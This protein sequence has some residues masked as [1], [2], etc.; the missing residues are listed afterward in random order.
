MVLKGLALLP[1]QVTKTEALKIFELLSVVN[2]KIGKIDSDIKNSVV[3]K[4]LI[5]SLSLKESVQSTRIEGTQVTF[6]EMVEEMNDK[7]PRW[8]IIEV[9]NYEQAL[10]EGVE[11]IRHGY[12]IST[13]LL[14]EL[15]S[16]LMH[17]ARGSRQS[18]GE[19]RK[20]Q[21]FI[22]PSTKIE[23]A[24][25]L[26]IGANEIGEYMSNLEHF[27]NGEHHFSYDKRV[28][29]DMY[30]FDETAPP[31]V[32]T[33]IIHAQFESI[34]PFLDGNGRLGR[35]LIVLSM[36]NENLTTEPI[37]LVSEELE[38]EKAR[39]YDML[40]EVRGDSPYWYNWLMF[41]LQ[42]CNRMADS[43]IVKIKDSKELA[44]RGLALCETNS[45]RKV[46]LGS[47]S[48]PFTTVKK[49]AEANWISP[50]TARLA[51]KNLVAKGLLYSDNQT[52]RNKRYRNYD[53]MRILDN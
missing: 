33:A 45:E 34:R 39:Y 32:K 17:G 48:D 46:W 3:N 31:L 47:F 4:S 29:E 40:N 44:I 1:V 16:I 20:I 5:Q 42:A 30:L 41:F 35:I 50:N 24:V 27:I 26:P 13:R 38:K 19:Y 23:D 37:F 43:L 8:E 22:G 21:N 49:S 53:L 15:H 7:N 18:S 6:T 12:P 25:Y 10:R 9:E 11:R 36:L 51:L 28:S 2:N 52:K 14:Q